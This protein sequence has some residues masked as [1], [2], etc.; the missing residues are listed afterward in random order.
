MVAD[1]SYSL[2]TLPATINLGGVLNATI[3]TGGTATLGAT[4]ANSAAA[5]ANNLNYALGAA[6]QSGSATLGTVVS[7]SGSLMPSASQA[8]TVAA[9]ATDLGVNTILFTASDP[10]STNLSQTATATL[11]VL[12]HA[13]PG[14]A[15][16][17]G[18]GFL[19]HA[20]ATGLSATVSLSNAAGTSSD[21]QVG[22]AP[23]IAAGTLNGDPATPFFLSAGSAQTFTATFNAG[24]T[25]GPFSDAVTF[26]SLGDDQSLPGANPPGPLSV[27]IAGAVYSGNAQWNA[28]NGV[29]GTTANWQDAVGGGPSAAP[30]LA[31]FASDTATFGSAAAQGALFVKLDGSAPS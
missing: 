29:W 19:A 15:V 3:I 1:Y 7:A 20:G 17:L 22:S 24:N 12:G 27:S 31:G 2:A 28:R 13:A 18:N 26:A 6:V 30:G 8:C 21:L 10:N 11:T 14:L 25:P 9:T 23:T 4:V 16:T 5:G